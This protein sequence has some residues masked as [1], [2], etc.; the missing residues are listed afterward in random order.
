MRKKGGSLASKKIRSLLII[1][2]LV[3]AVFAF[4]F[5]INEASVVSSVTTEG[6]GSGTLGVNADDTDASPLSQD[7][8]ALKA[9]ISKE[10][11]VAL[12]SP[13]KNLLPESYTL[14]ETAYYEVN[15]INIEVDAITKSTENPNLYNVKLKNGQVFKATQEQLHNT[16]WNLEPE[17]GRGEKPYTSSIFGNLGT[18]PWAFALD[19]ILTGFQIAAAVVG[20]I[21][22][23]GGLFGLD[24]G[25]TSALS[26]G[27]FAGIMA[28]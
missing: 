10:A 7:F 6:D 22:L 9:R 28:G 12:N 1:S 24:S 5:V 21:Q 11:K 16:K 15:G 19:N 14:K 13:S 27:A 4:A 3:L 20:V 18:G 2:N 25:L 23:L 26:Y 17:L 8:D